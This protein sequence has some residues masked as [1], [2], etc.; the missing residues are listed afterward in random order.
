[1]MVSTA[2]A[3]IRLPSRGRLDLANPDPNAWTNEDFASRLSRTYRWGGESAWPLPLS[4]GQHSLAV[5]A[6]RRQWDW[7]R[8]LS[9][10]EALQVLCHDGDE[11]FLMF[12]CIAPMKPILGEPFQGV[13]RRLMDAIRTRYGLPEWDH[14]AHI[15]L[16]RADL[17]AAATEA[18]HVAGWTRDEVVNVLGIKHPVLDVDPLVKMYGGKE[19][20][21][22]PSEVVAER[23]L[24]ELE[25]LLRQT[26]A[27][28]PHPGIA[29][30]A[31]TDA[32]TSKAQ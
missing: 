2:R 15:L 13:S 10:L 3:W 12:D 29:L 8:P 1:M 4:V 6:L 16:K 28:R 26:E 19:W 31:N 25:S 24:R 9:P 21:P 20:E 23:F 32:A 7:M 14:A 22:W 30:S 18:V 5:L 27:S 17:I 11:A